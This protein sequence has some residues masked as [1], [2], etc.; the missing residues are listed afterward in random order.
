MYPN[1]SWLD[2]G[3]VRPVANSHEYQTLEELAEIYPSQ[4]WRLATK[5]YGRGVGMALVSDDGA[6]LAVSGFLCEAMGVKEEQLIGRQIHDFFALPPE[7]DSALATLGSA[8]PASDTA[9]RGYIAIRRQLR[10]H[11]A[12]LQWLQ[13]TSEEIDKAEGGGYLLIL[14]D[15]SATANLAHGLREHVGAA[16]KALAIVAHDI[17]TPLTTVLLSG[18]L[19]QSVV[20]K[21]TAAE[22]ATQRIIDSAS[23]A[24]QIADDLVDLSRWKRE[25]ALEIKL[26]PTDLGQLATH[27]LE[28]YALSHPN[29]MIVSQQTGNLQGHWDPHRLA[30]MLSNLLNNALTHGA[31]SDRPV[32]VRLRGR[33]DT[34]NIEVH[35]AG[36]IHAGPDLQAIFAPSVTSRVRQ[37]GRNL[38][39]G[40]FI[41][42][43][44]VQAH[45]GVI[46]VQSSEDAGTCFSITL[47]RHGNDPLQFSQEN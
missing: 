45:G 21:E 46:S 39:L 12:S 14:M 29:R 28:N 44:I 16:E 35:N 38:G 36:G 18:D 34:I 2:G 7:A 41:V 37:P 47:P 26:Q 13:G 17:R 19:L 8:Q 33:D 10:R 31:C 30:Q 40:L 15:A 9:S 32:E 25:K 4:A 11:D 3:E 22:R 27:L 5:R 42:E 20:D 23:Q 1:N 24:L 6:W 43:K